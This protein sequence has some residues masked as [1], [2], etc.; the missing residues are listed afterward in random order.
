MFNRQ[1]GLTIQ[2]GVNDLIA[3][4]RLSNLTVAKRPKPG[5]TRTA[6]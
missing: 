5:Y 4:V 3:G 6:Q 2:V 1:V